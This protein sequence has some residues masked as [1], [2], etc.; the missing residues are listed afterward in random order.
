MNRWLISAG[1]AL[2]IAVLWADSPA[3]QGAEAVYCTNCGTE[4]TQLLNKAMMVKQ[5]ATQAQQLSTQIGQYKD[6]VTNSN[7]VSQH[8]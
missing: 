2:G 4:W 6:M 1:L 7:G 8:L 3:V 5:L